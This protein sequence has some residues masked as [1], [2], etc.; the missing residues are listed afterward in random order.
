MKE[1]TM[2]AIV[3]FDNIVRAYTKGKQALNGVSFSIEEGEVVGLLG[4]NGAGKTT[5]IR[6]AMGMLYPHSGSVRMF[7]LSPT[8]DPVAVKKRIG[9]VAEE[10]TLPAGSSIAE[11]IAFHRY[12][13]PS[14]DGSLERQILERFFDLTG[15][16]RILHLQYC[17]YRGPAQ[18]EKLEPTSLSPGWRKFYRQTSPCSLRS[19]PSW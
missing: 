18:T 12:L 14:W 15:K 3:E 11:L 19:A 7:G 5:L 4:R 16:S 13:F 8:Q 6:I 2:S 17:N 10:Q 1:K 9:Y